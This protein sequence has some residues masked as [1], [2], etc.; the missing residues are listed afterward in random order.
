MTP[1]RLPPT[2]RSRRGIHGHVGRLFER[3]ALEVS[4][5]ICQ[6]QFSVDA[7]PETQ[8]LGDKDQH[9]DFILPEVPCD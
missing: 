5:V 1:P 8:P 7:T 4:S 2:D 6:V 3:L 9:R